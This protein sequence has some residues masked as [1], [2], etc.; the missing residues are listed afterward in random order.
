MRTFH[1]IPLLAVW[2]F[3]ACGG[4]Q[5]Q[6]QQQTAPAVQLT[7]YPASVEYADAKLNGFTYDNGKFTYDYD[8]SGSYKL[9]EQTTDADK[10]MCANSGKGQHIHFIL[11]A[12]PYKAFY[13]NEFE[14]PLEDG[15]YHLLSFLS[16]SYHESIKNGSAHIAQKI[17]VNGGK[18]KGEAMTAPALFYSRP[19]GT[20]V[21]KDTK[22][23]M[24]DFFIVNAE[25]GADYKVK[26][27]VNDAELETL[28]EW[29]PYFLEGLPMG[30]NTV[31][32][33]LVDGE[34]NTVE[35]PN[36]PVS[37]EFELLEQPKAE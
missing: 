23:V 17:I 13:T 18:L 33:E 19:K 29:K 27:T 25:L 4:G 15:E 32:L 8:Q 36:N 35:A 34:G 16:R 1:V 6:G 12:E 2:L 22:K 3:A 26:V 28:D 11:G 7:D 5:E 14:N 21:G 30:K 9:G 20:Y 24:L 37:R 10:K 31:T